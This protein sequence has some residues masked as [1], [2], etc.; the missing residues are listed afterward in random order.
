MPLTWRGATAAA[1]RISELAG[2]GLNAMHTGRANQEPQVTD[3]IFGAIEGAIHENPIDG[4]SWQ[5]HTLGDRGAKSPESRFGADALVVLDIKVAGLSA[6]KG[7]LAQAKILEPEARMTQAEFNDL[8]EQ[9]TKMLALTPDAFVW[10]YHRNG[11]SVIPALSVVGLST[12]NRRPGTA[13]RWKFEY[14]IKAFIECFV[15]DQRFREATRAELER[16]ADE[17]AARNALLLEARE[18]GA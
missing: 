9:C 6:C 10:L 2:V 14:F 8:R 13:S 4:I 12:E 15:G 18:D 1:D 17:V 11:V 7:I 5:A 3:R 16:I